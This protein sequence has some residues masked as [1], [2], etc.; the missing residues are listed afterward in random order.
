MLGIF[1]RTQKTPPILKLCSAIKAMSVIVVYIAY[2]HH[3]HKLAALCH[4]KAFAKN[5]N[6]FLAY[7]LL[8][9]C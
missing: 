3:I 8:Q 7:W 2:H 9:L 5:I 4:L 6:G 1:Q